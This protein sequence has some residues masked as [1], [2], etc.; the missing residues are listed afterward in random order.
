MK[1]ATTRV[2]SRTIHAR[3]C[4]NQSALNSGF[5]DP[6]VYSCN[7]ACSHAP[8]LLTIQMY[9]LIKKL[10]SSWLPFLLSW[11][12][13]LPWWEPSS[14]SLLG[15]IYVC[16]FLLSVNTRFL[17]F[18]IQFSFLYGISVFPLWIVR[19]LVFHS[20]NASWLIVSLPRQAV[21]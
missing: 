5:L 15:P 21:H 19:L 18:A 11:W 2:R 16:S 8:S 7:D 14:L 6:R 17:H 10:R 12:T 9:A 3:T 20:L 1:P 4:A 13:M